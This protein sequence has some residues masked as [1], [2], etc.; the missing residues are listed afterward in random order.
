MATGASNLAGER[1]YLFSRGYVPK[2]SG[3]AEGMV[4]V[5]TSDND[6]LI[7]D[8]PNAATALNG[9][10]NFVGISASAGSTI[11]SSNS[12]P[13]DN[14][15]TVD[16]A[17]ISKCLLK[18]GNACEKYSPAGYDPTDGGTVVPHVSGKT[19]QIG[20]FTQSKS[21][22][23][24]NQMVGVWLDQ[25]GA[26]G[27]SLL[28][29]IVAASA[30]V[31]NTATET[32]FDKTITIPAN[33]L[34]VGAVLRISGRVRVTSGNSTNTLTLKLKVGSQVILTTAAV[35]VTDGGGDIG[36]FSAEVTVRTIGASGT[37]TASGSSGLGV[38]GTAT[39]R[40]DGLAAASF[41]ADTTAALVISATATW[42]V[43]SASNSCQLEDLSAS[44]LRASV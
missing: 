26:Q 34:S 9:G 14:Q 38:I 30:A 43:A 1:M 17:G 11:V 10:R 19:V 35:D 39:M 23:G 32:A 22:S 16:L 18:A 25:G 20:R 7:V 42:S 29:S 5:A 13:S 8:L 37:L 41:T 6:N 3:I 40:V 4:V 28:G 2:S 21:S 44:L 24:S 31:S 27:E 33:L 36:V 12:L 15:I